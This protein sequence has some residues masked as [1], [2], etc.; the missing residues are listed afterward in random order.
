MYKA[1]LLS[2][3]TTLIS[4]WHASNLHMSRDPNWIRD[5]EEYNS[6]VID[7][8]S[9]VDSQVYI[10]TSRDAKYKEETLEAISM[11][12][13][14]KPDGG[15]FNDTCYDSA[16]VARVKSTLLDRLL[17]DT[18]LK[19]DEVYIFESNKQ[20]C[21]VWKKKDVPHKLVTK[22]SHLPCIGWFT[23]SGK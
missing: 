2:L 7:W 21:R 11:R 10:F 23:E 6:W 15:Y 16:D 3:N 8:L 14:W 1:I 5:R 9:E 22:P 18:G 19:L 20:A 17:E 12:L 4:N 13:S